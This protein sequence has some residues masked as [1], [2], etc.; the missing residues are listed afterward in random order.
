MSGTQLT[1]WSRNDGTPFPKVKD[2]SDPDD[3]YPENYVT[4]QLWENM[5]QGI[6]RRREE[7]EFT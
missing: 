1:G 2:E 6:Q 5:Y 4:K 7:S 3:L